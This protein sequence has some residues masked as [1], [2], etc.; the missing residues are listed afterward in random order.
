MLDDQTFNH[1]VDKNLTTT[2]G[3]YVEQILSDKNYFNIVLP[4]IPVLMHRDI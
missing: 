3:Q 2:F 1:S 4:R